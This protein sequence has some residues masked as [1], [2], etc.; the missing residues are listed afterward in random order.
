MPTIQMPE[1]EPFTLP[2]TAEA[3]VIP[4]PVLPS[5]DPI[6]MGPAD[7]GEFT[8]SIEEATKTASSV[9]NKGVDDMAGCWST[10]LDNVASAASTAYS[11]MVEEAGNAWDE[12]TTAAEN[13]ARKIVSA[14][15]RITA[16]GKEAGRAASIKMG[17]D[18]PHNARGTDNWKGGPTYMN[19]E[20]GELA[21]LPGGSAII[22][23]DQ[24]DRLMSSFNSNVTNQQNSRS[25]TFSPKLEIKV[26][27]GGDPQA[28]AEAVE[29]RIRAMFDELYAEAQEKDYT[30]RAMQQGYA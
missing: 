19:E 11:G 20:G 24:T 3:P 7:T 22:P 2:V 16:A 26:E 1:V 15:E 23:A 25:M 21:V 29:A 12:M 10:G 27:G 30:E 14:L 18:I 4:D 5:I 6:V 8:T 13:G 28:T 9:T 17:A